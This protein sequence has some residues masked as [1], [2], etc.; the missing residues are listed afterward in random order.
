[1]NRKESKE[2]NVTHRVLIGTTANIILAVTQLKARPHCSTGGHL[3][4]GAFTLI[5]F[6]LFVKRLYVLKDLSAMAKDFSGV[7]QSTPNALHSLSDHVQYIDIF[8][9]ISHTSHF[10]LLCGMTP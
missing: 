5:L 4:A 9:D 8:S 1:M 6:I 2:V 7:L 10:L 3:D